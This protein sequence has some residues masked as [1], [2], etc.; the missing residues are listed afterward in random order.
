[1]YE[2]P[3]FIIFFNSTVNRSLSFSIEGELSR[4]LI[5]K[6]HIQVQK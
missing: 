2:I 6:S 1:M 4:N 3:K 5:L